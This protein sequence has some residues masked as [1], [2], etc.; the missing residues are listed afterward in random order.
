MPG[1]EIG[2]IAR[3]ASRVRAASSDFD[4]NPGSG[5]PPETALRPAAVLLAFQEGAGG[6]R[7]ILTKRSAAL[8]HHPGQIALP[9][10]KLD[11]QDAGPVDAALREAEEE[12]GLARGNAEVFATL[13][14]HRTVTGFSVTPVLARV[15]TAFDP[16]PEAGEVEDVFAVPYRFLA[17]P[18]N[19][20]VQS[21]L[22]H[23]QRRR[24]YTIPWGPYYIWGATARILRALAEGGADGGAD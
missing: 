17:R 10:G 8:R 19:Y 4:L 23:G 3:A 7:L 11:R 5:G 14:P 16:V 12:I 6:L 22:W 21:R 18:E 13:P 24:Y 9:G 15:R 2:E 1:S 20:V